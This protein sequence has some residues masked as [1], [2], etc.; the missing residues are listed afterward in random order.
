MRAYILI[1][2]S[3]DAD[4]SNVQQA[5]QR[6]G[7]TSVDLVMGPYDVIVSCDVANFAAL[8]ALAKGIH[9]GAGISESVTCPVA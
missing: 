3:A 8:S 9:G 5:L 6:P 7:V 2:L 4:L 1:K